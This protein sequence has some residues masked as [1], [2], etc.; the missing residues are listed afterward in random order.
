MRLCAL[1]PLLDAC[2]QAHPHHRHAL[3]E[4]FGGCILR[5][6]DLQVVLGVNSDNITL[7]SVEEAIRPCG[8]IVDQT[9]GDTWICIRLRGYRRESIRN[10]VI[11][12]SSTRE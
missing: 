9:L 10:G 12:E 11:Q 5:A 8:E 3:R 7:L 6:P 1:T 4:S 2:C